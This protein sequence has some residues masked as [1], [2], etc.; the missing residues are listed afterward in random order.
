[1]KNISLKSAVYFAFRESRFAVKNFRSFIA[2]LFL[3]TAIIAGI[4]SL[5][6]N[7]SDSLS[8]DGQILLGGDVEISQIQQRLSPEERQYLS[9]RGIVSE[10]ATLR[11]MAHGR[12]DSSLI[13]LKAVDNHY[14]LY[15]TLLLENRSYGPDILSRK[16]GQWGILLSEALIIRLKL[17]V[18]DTVTVGTEQ[19]QV[20]A[21]LKKQPDVNS[22]RFQLAP[23]A[24]IALTSLF[25]NSLVQPGSL[26]RYHN[27]IKLNQGVNLEKL[28]HNIQKRFSGKG[29]QI[30]DSHSGGA[31]LRRFISRMGQFMTL[32]GLTALLVG[33]IGVSNGVHAYLEEKTDTIATYK[34]LGA[35]GKTILVAYLGQI[36]A[37]ALGAIIFG[38]IVGA[39][40]PVILAEFFRS[41]LP[42]AVN[43][44]IYLKPLGVAA[45]YSLSVALIFTLWPLGRAV[46]SSPARL[47]R[48][49]VSPGRII[50]RSPGYIMVIS[51]LS[52]SLIAL[53][54]YLSEFRLLTA[55]I[56][57]A[58]ALVF[59]IL[60]GASALARRIARNI[61]RPKNPVFRIA[62]GNIYRPGNGTTSI[63]LSLGFGLILFTTIALLENNLL[64]AIDEQT[65][66]EAPS[67]FF[68][69]IQKSQLE[70]FSDFLMNR[71]GV[72][73][74]RTVPNLRGKIT[75]IKSIDASKV[76]VKP[77]GRWI[78]RGDKGIT[79]T[80]KLPGDNE[81][82]A[83]HWWPAGYH[84]PPQ[85]SISEQMARSMDLTPGDAIS[86]NILGRNF[87]LPIASVRRFSWGSLGIN[88]VLMLDPNTL[89]SAPFTYV[90]TARAQKEDEARIYQ[91]I[92]RKFPAISIVRMKEILANILTLLGKI[93]GSIDIMA[94]ITILSGIFV[95]AGAVGAGHKARIYDAAVLKVV[96]ATRWNIVKAYALEFILLGVVTGVIALILG[97]LGAYAI[98]TYLMELSWQ[99][100]FYIPLSTVMVSTGITLA[101]GMVSIW[102]ALS[103]RPSQ[104]L[105]NH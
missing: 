69:D 102:L 33:G 78:L 104:T 14:P 98:I 10:I 43:M 20:R 59:M 53:V 11:T 68:I 99:L 105:R 80:D 75:R 32:I 12:D 51:V 76:A 39:L 84:G 70:A 87:T 45:Y 16:N 60:L 31:G 5:T 96:G 77:E 47:F 83:G 1:M 65:R 86:V 36:M 89:K 73:S 61:P 23:G 62:L 7:I 42:V 56:L 63:I 34:I 37:I 21:V 81:I 41:S 22:Q 92:N 8:Q 90:A 74:Y 67:F 82:I 15:G 72:K 91:D 25:E 71:K 49:T 64:R 57:G 54:I 26:I 46:R 40:L 19:Y 3:G 38:V 24:I 27:R 28:K 48:Q 2:C 55:A 88:Y 79:F 6:A 66:G 17:S 4:G 103:V 101:F 44:T 85:V 9:E 58:M 29:G 93:A 18:G 95:L 13:D 97:T 94:A 30:R 100:P 52:L 50:S 35:T